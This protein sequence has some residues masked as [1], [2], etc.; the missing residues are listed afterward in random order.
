MIAITTKYL[1]PTNFRGA[2]IKATAGEWSATISYRYALSDEAL[3]FEAVKELVI[4]HSLDWDISK[5][6]YGGTDFG[7][8]FCF[9][10]SIIK[11]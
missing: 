4:M 2:R 7:Y 9:P 6:V 11:F 1:A 3:H 5:M 8:V 10:E